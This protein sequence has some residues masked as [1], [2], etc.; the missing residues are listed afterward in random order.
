MTENGIAG[1]F[2]IK[3]ERPT[4]CRPF[5]CPQ[6][7]LQFLQFLASEAFLEAFASAVCSGFGVFHVHS[8]W[9][10]APCSDFCLS[11]VVCRTVCDFILFRAGEFLPH[12]LGRASH[13]RVPMR[14]IIKVRRA[15]RLPQ[16]S[17]QDHKN[18]RSRG[19]PSRGADP[20]KRRK[21]SDVQ[22]FGGVSLP[23]RACV[24]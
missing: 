12:S 5:R 4:N 20:R 9:G 6:T 24:I 14:F 17:A 21:V 3:A 23:S 18:K 8:F 19:I 10:I 22:L 2:P 7:Y 15:L 13:P 16:C 1:K 11:R